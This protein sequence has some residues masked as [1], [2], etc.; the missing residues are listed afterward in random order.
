MLL[1]YILLFD[2]FSVAFL[3]RQDPHLI[4]ACAVTFGVYHIFEAI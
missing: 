3:R 4:L 1:T 2:G